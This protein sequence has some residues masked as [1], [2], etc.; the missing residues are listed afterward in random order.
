MRRLFG[1]LDAVGGPIEAVRSFLRI[2]PFT[3]GNGR[4]AFVLYNWLNH[5]LLAPAP[6]PDFDW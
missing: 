3:D 5:T 6:L 4:V 2:H 1:A